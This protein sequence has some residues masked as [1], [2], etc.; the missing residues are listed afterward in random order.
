MQI[1]VNRA[2]GHNTNE[3]LKGN[4]CWRVDEF[5]SAALLAQIAFLFSSKPKHRANKPFPTVLFQEQQTSWLINLATMGSNNLEEQALNNTLSAFRHHGHIVEISPEQGIKLL[6]SWLQ[7]LQGDPNI[8]QIKGQLG[9][10]RS[11]LQTTPP[12]D[13]YIRD[14]LL[15]LADKTQTVAED[16]NSEGTW[17][18]GLESLSK[19][20]RDFGSK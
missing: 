15:S 5:P 2:V 4:L 7:A 9:E 8:D 19:I 18:G 12:D 13:Q 17:T 11:A 1:P 14:L 16:A 20:L 6:D 3:P 10:L